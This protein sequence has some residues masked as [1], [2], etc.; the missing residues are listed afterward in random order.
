[1]KLLVSHES[2]I[3]LFEESLN[4]NDYQYCLVHLMEENEEYRDW[5][6]TVNKRFGADVLLD[7]SIFELG[8]SFDP[9]KYGYW[10]NQ[11]KPNYYIIPDV[12]ENVY[13][14]IDK[15]ERWVEPPGVDALKIGVVQGKT[16]Q[17]LTDCYRFMSEK[18]DYIAISFDYSYYNY[19]GFG[20]DE[21]Q[22]WCS[23]RQRFI[24]DLIDE[25]IWNWN[26]PHHL[27]GCSLAKEFKYY[28]DNRITNIRSCDTSNPI[29]AA[30]K[31]L[32]YNGDLGLTQKPSTMLCD[33]INADVDEDV[34]ELSRYNTTMFKH[35]LGRYGELQTST[36]AG[37]Y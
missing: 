18:A 21:L 34:L 11:I 16:W 28:V 5:F 17:E 27:L 3:E 24:K 29:V 25:G 32:R 33:L 36:V 22:R 14:T 19:T 31:G 26:K 12:L 35:I 4:Y 9:E 23:G 30:L 20:D 8:E 13:G 1:M 10:L 6:M 37:P 7:N 2:P 15:W